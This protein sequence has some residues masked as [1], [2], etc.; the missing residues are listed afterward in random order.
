MAKV[1]FKERTETNVIFV[2]CSATKPTQDIGARDIRIWH[3]SDNGWLDIGYHFVIRRNGVIED[4]RPVNVV[5]AHAY[6]YNGDSV[7][8][9]LVG[10]INAQGQADANF[11]CE[12]YEA[13]KV[14]LK[15]LKASYPKA[16]VKGHCDVSDK[17]CPSFDVHSFIE[18]H[19]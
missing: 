4:G 8:V 7:A 12:Q 6:G 2:H 13:L 18:N 15:T 5:G 1:K 11:T 19:L 10:G 16:E 14:L 9:C 3:K 17:A